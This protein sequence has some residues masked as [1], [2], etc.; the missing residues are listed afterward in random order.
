[1]VLF[2]A[3]RVV[4]SVCLRELRRCVHR[5]RLRVVAAFVS[6][7]ASA[8][9]VS[10]VVGAPAFLAGF[11]AFPAGAGAR[12][13]KPVRSRT[14]DPASNPGAVV[15]NIGVVAVA[16]CL[17]VCAPCPAYSSEPVAHSVAATA[18]SD[19]SESTTSRLMAPATG[20][21][22]GATPAP[23]W[24]SSAAPSSSSSRK[25]QEM[26]RSRCSARLH[27]WWRGALNRRSIQ[28]PNCTVRRSLESPYRRCHRGTRPSGVAKSEVVVY[29]IDHRCYGP[30]R[31]CQEEKHDSEA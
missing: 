13:S 16:S 1:M 5:P 8:S 24:S 18:R 10:V 9:S 20:R 11:P 25:L 27:D 22:A 21:H 7:Y 6:M 31:S 30:S 2:V 14:D 26:W 19:S 3:I 15:P 12:V 28:Q 17:E 4:L 29:L 23:R